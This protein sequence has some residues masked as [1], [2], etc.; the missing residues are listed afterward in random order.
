[1]VPAELKYIESH[2][3]VR[4]SEDIATVGITDYAQDKL[5]DVVFIELP[6]VGK[7]LRSSE[8][9]G[10]IESV[11]ATSEL[12]SPIGGEIVEVNSELVEHPEWVNQSPYERGWML[13]IKV[14]DPKELEQLLTAKEYEAKL[15]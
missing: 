2:E 4:L 1:M 8:K 9:F 12:Y 3:W 5:G 10:D 7:Q 14:A 15:E 6:P 11:K 13:R